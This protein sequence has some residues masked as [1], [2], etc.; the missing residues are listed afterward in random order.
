[1]GSAKATSACEALLLKPIPA[2]RNMPGGCR[3]TMKR[4]PSLEFSTISFNVRKF[5]ERHKAAD[6]ATR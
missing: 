5:T 2:I 6:C 4:M 1:M 3:P